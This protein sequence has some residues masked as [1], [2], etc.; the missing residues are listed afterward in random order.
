MAENSVIGKTDGAIASPGNSNIW[1]TGTIGN[2]IT[3]SEDVLTGPVTKIESGLTKENIR[4]LNRINGGV[5]DHY[6]PKS[7]NV[8][9]IWTE[10]KGKIDE[11]QTTNVVVNISDTKVSMQTLQNQ[12]TQWPILGMDKLIII[13]KSGNVIRVK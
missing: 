5:F 1:K 2:A 11:G 3:K 7:S 8:R 10:V 13:D 12:F 9:N 4:S 6:A